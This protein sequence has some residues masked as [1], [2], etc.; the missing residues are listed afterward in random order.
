MY[1]TKLLIVALFLVGIA[2]TGFECASTELTS[3]RLYIQQK[4]YP[5]A[6]DALHQEVTKN[7]KS[8]EGYYLL[9]YVNGELGHYDEMIGDFDKSLAISKE[10]EKS[11]TDSK[12]YYWAQA[13]NKGVDFFQKAGKVSN[14]DSVQVN[15]DRSAHEF[16]MATKLEPDSVAAYQNLAF[17]YINQRELD[18]AIAPLKKIVSTQHGLDGYRYLGEIYYEKASKLDTKYSSSKDVQD[19]VQAQD[20]YKK[21]IDVLQEGRKYFPHN[22]ELLGYLSNSYIGA[23][24][25]Q[26]ALNAFKAGVEEDPGNKYY[27]YNYGVVLLNND[28]FPVA[29][30]QFEKALEIDSTYE[31]AMYNLAVTYVKWGTKINKDAQEKDEKAPLNKTKYE[32]AL[33]YLEHLVKMRDDNVSLWDLL[34][35]VYAVLGQQQKAQDAFNKA[36][37]L[38]K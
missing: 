28:N 27:R 3:A 36:D 33:P 17:V 37:A 22:S 4:N 10:Y 24:Q 12:R 35:K 18:S 15:Y 20:Y 9:G 11:I 16:K 19:S 32:Q 2:V 26:I 38:R 23:H 1:R 25:I 5:K 34:G 7:P 21:A 29:A 6:L 30:E 13:Y 14:K 31:N 8:Y